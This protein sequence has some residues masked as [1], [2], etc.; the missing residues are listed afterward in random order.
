VL[1][2]MLLA[3]GLHAA[4]AIGKGSGR[5]SRWRLAVL[6]V[7]A[8]LLYLLGRQNAAQAAFANATEL[9]AR[10]DWRAAAQAM[11]QAVAADPAFRFYQAQRGYAYGV[12]ADPLTQG[13]DAGA[14]G[15]AIRSYSAALQAGPE[16][17]P[18]L[19]NAAWLQERAGATQEAE[20]LLERAVQRGA[21]WA[22]P[23]LLLGQRYASQGR[24]AEAARLR[25]GVCSRASGAENGGV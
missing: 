11:D 20:R 24:H 25:A 10:G 17:V 1:C 22:L 18:D 9:A 2:M 5:A 14:L 13:R 6:A 8:L 7:P 16:Y 12:L 21:D 4:G 3:L 19:L 23:A 15:P